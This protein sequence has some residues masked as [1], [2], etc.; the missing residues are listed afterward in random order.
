MVNVYVNGKG[1]IHTQRIFGIETYVGRPPQPL[2][3][4]VFLIPHLAFW[5]RALAEVLSLTCLTRRLTQS[6][7][8][9][10]RITSSIG[11]KSDGLSRDRVVCGAWRARRR[12]VRAHARYARAYS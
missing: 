12:P 1:I 3:E 7:A 4:T 2:V 11:W 9:C 6:E 10:S 8:T 5:G